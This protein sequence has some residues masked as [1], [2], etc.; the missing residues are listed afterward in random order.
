M[1]RRPKVTHTGLIMEVRD[2]HVWMEIAGT[3]GTLVTNIDGA[4]DIARRLLVASFVAEQPD[5]LVPHMF[6]VDNVIENKA[7]GMNYEGS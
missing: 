1:P 5:G 3:G 7:G 4:R 2:G 6:V